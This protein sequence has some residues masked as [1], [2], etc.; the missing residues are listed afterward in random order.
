M[1]IAVC[2]R[3]LRSTVALLAHQIPSPSIFDL[4]VFFAWRVGLVVFL[5]AAILWI[6]RGRHLA[7]WLGVAAIGGLAIITFSKPD[8]TEYANCA[9]QLGGAIGRYMLIPVLLVWWAYAAAFSRKAKRYFSKD[10]KDVV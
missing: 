8:T 6:H 1:C 5:V 2:F 3:L 7:R 10:R 9:Q 4:M